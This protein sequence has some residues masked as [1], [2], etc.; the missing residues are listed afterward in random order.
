MHRGAFLYLTQTKGFLPDEYRDKLGN[1]VYGCDSCQTSCPVNRRIDVHFHRE[2][3]AEAE[4]VKP[5]LL[6]LLKISNRDFKRRFGQL[7]GSWR[8]KKPIQ[9]NAIIALAHFKDR[10]AV[11]DLIDVLTNDPR[12]VMRGTVA[13]A[14]GKIGGEQANTALLM[15]LEKETDDEVQTEIEK[16][17]AFFS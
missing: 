15:A 1:R 10:S 3:E 14:L 16:G 4:V 13:W 6:P 11:P 8:G 5:Q 2:M 9:R 12:P 7:A 17:L